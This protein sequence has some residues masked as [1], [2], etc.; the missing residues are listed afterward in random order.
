MTLPPER[1]TTE[2]LRYYV[3]LFQ[4]GL[5]AEEKLNDDENLSTAERNLYEN[6]SRL[7]SLA[8][9]KVAQLSAPLITAEI[10]KLISNSHLPHTQDLFYLIYFGG[11]NGMKRGM[12]KFDVDKIQNSATNYLFQWFGVYAKRELA[13]AEAPYGVAP[14]RFQRYKKVS[15]VR[16]KMTAELEREP[17]NQEIFDYFQSGRADLKTMNGPLGSSTRSSG[18]NREITLE[19]IAEQETFERSYMHTE[20]FNPH[21]DYSTEAR[22]AQEDE[23]AF[24]QTFFGIFVEEFLINKK[25]K[26]VL[27]SDLGISNVPDELEEIVSTMDRSEYARYSRA[28]AELIRDPRGPFLHFLKTVKKEDFGQFDIMGTIKTIED[29]GSKNKSRAHKYAMLFEKEER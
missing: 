27:V 4:R 26:A 15:A 7:A 8:L 21:E 9:S 12:A 14:S 18:A 3:P 1:L 10:N 23:D 5:R 29:S 6:E 20:L 11:L 25:A 16:K 22:L 19:F 2:A 28:W 13:A 17:T 24:S